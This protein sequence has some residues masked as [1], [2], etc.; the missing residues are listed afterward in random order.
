MNEFSV[1]YENISKSNFFNTD[2]FYI[3]YVPGTFPITKFTVYFRDYTQ[4]EKYVCFI[5]ISLFDTREAFTGNVGCDFKSSQDFNPY[6]NVVNGPVGNFYVDRIEFESKFIDEFG[7]EQYLGAT[8]ATKWSNGE[9]T[10]F[11][12]GCYINNT[13]LICDELG[14]KD[15]SASFEIFKFPKFNLTE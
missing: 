9:T 8:Y 3:N 5:D 12:S 1:N 7:L 10:R 6:M 14:G 4:Y 15:I 13:N 11:S 2:I